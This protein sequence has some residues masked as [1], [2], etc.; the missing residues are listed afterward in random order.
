M[1]MVG[2]LRVPWPPTL[3]LPIK[4][5]T[6]FLAAS[7]S[8]TLALECVIDAAQLPASLPMAMVRVLFYTLMPLATL[9]LL[10]LV[11]LLV[12]LCFAVLPPTI[13]QTRSRVRL[14]FRG[15]LMT[16]VSCSGMPGG[17]GGCCSWPVFGNRMRKSFK[18]LC[19]TSVVLLFVCCFFY[20]PSVVRYALSMFVCVK[21]DDAN[22]IP[23][24]WAAAAPRTYFLLDL[25]EKCWAQGGW[26]RTWALAYGVPLVLLLCGALPSGLAGVIWAHK[27]HLH[28]PWFRRRYGWVVRVYR[29]E[30]AAWEAVVVCKTIMMCMCAVFGMA[31]GVFHQTLL[32]AAICAG[33]AVLLMV[34]EPH[35]ERQLQHL[36]VYAFGSLFITLMAALSFLTSFN[37][38]EPP[39]AYSVA[40]G[41]V[42]LAANLAYIA[43]AVYVL[44]G[45]IEVQWDVQRTLSM[46]MQLLSKVVPARLSGILGSPV[47]QQQQQQQQHQQRRW[48]WKQ[49]TAG[50]IV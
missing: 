21:L 20:L 18:G 34:F 24:A 17:R 9:L 29:P 14:I 12:R 15:H 19:S 27:R 40:M 16:A 28:A 48:P 4:V 8:Q 7:S 32:M 31:L 37:D 25:N 33:F 44:K 1:L 39:Y 35:E 22:A 50:N 36:L 41:G 13:L 5:L 11:E 6:W 47:R 42:V 49:G 23:Y 26:H 46:M 43:W 3:L 38:I 2:S 30:R 45:A 10:W